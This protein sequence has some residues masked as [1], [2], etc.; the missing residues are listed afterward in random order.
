[1][2]RDN[3]FDGSY[4][5]V[6]RFC[7]S[8]SGNQP[9]LA[10]GPSSSGRTQL[11]PTHLLHLSVEAATQSILEDVRDA[12]EELEIAAA[13]PLPEPEVELPAEPTVDEPIVLAVV[14]EPANDLVSDEEVPYDAA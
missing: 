2:A 12:M 10:S 13:A 6:K 9:P 8:L 7:R 5:A 11:R 3:K 4:D 1:M 14:D